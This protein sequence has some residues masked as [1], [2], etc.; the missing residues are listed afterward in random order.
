MGLAVKGVETRLT[1]AIFQK[2][3]PV[4]PSSADANKNAPLNLFLPS[5][6]GVRSYVMVTR[7]RV[8]KPV[9]ENRFSLIIYRI[10]VHS[11]HSE[12]LFESLHVKIFE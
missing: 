6:V 7:G 2:P 8:T 3:L 5:R 9:N 11:W 12:A 10:P 4:L 1:V